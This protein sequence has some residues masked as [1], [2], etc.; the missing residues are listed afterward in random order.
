M[1]LY[2]FITGNI[3]GPIIYIVAY[4]VRT[5]IFFPA[6]WM[7]ILSGIVFGPIWGIVY[8]IL[9]E[10]ICASIAYRIGKK[11]GRNMIKPHK[12]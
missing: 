3:R 7:M 9:G 5:V 6:T 11:F 10:N 4:S 12:Q 1:M 8:S 2:E